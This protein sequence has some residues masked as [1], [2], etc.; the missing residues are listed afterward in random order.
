MHY[1]QVER[2]IKLFIKNATRDNPDAKEENDRFS[3]SKYGALT[4]QYVESIKK[5]KPSA[6]DAILQEASW[7][8]KET[9]DGVDLKGATGAD[10]DTLDPNR[11][12]NLE[13]H[14]DDDEGGSGHQSVEYMHSDCTGDGNRSGQYMDSGAGNM[15]DSFSTEGDNSGSAYAGDHGEYQEEGDEYT[16]SEYTLGDRSEYAGNHSEDMGLE[17][18]EDDSVPARRSDSVGSAEYYEDYTDVG[19]D[20]CSPDY[21]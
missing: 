2:A 13:E 11:R 6:W 15:D 17:G 12:A 10:A 9:K 20:K 8:A 7:F 16:S 5:L 18:G 14:S 21:I 3:E 19:G 1:Y 4:T